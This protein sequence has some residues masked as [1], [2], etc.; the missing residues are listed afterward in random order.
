MKLLKSNLIISSM[1]SAVAL[2][3]G[4]AHAAENPMQAAYKSTNVK[5]AIINV[6]KDQTAKGGKLSSA[7][8]SKF[9][10]CQVEAQGKVTEAQKWEIQS[11]INAK[12]SPSTLAFV[13][14]QN[15]E[16]K[17]CFGPQLTTKLE[18]LTADAI[19]AAQAQQGKKS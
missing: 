18:K 11:A 7:E 5:G 19:K 10:T 2:M 8:V 3:A 16:L 13:Q 14:Q 6:C 1:F 15:S 12:K 17:A 4:A 9:C